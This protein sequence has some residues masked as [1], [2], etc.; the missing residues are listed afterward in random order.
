M[1]RY[2][3]LPEDKPRWPW[4]MGLVLLG[5]LTALA[6]MRYLS[7]R[8]TVFDL[9]V[10][11][12]NLTAMSQG[13]EWWRALNGHIQPVLWL[14][15]WLIRP[16]PDW[17][18]PL[19]LMVAQA[20]MLALPLPF[21]G[22]R[23]GV[24]AALA[25]FGYFAVWH[26][27][28]FDFHPD[29]LAIPLGFWFFFR[30]QDED[31]WGAA[32]AA[33]SLCLVKETFAL[34]AA[35][36]GVYLAFTRGGGPAGIFVSAAGL[37]WFWLATAKLIPFFTMDA[38][39]GVTAG[40]FAWI[41]GA[42]V[43]GK[44]WWVLMHPVDTLGHVLGDPRKLKYLGALFGSLAF[45]PLLSPGPLFTV[46]PTLALSLLSSR[47]DYYSVTNHYTAGLVAPLIVA[48]ARALPLAAEAVNARSGRLDRWAGTLFLVLL[49]GHVLLAAS[50][51]SIP[52]WRGGGGGGFW[53][54]ERDTRII[55]AMEKN[56]PDD[57]AE[58][59]I[60][61]NSLNWGKAVTR[62]FSNSFPLAVFEPHLAQ[63]SRQATLRDFRRYVL[64]GI[65]P[66]FPVTR[67]LARYVVLDLKRPWFMVDQG[68]EWKDGACRDKA[69][70]DAFLENL[71][72]A[73]RDFDTLVEDDGFLILKRKEP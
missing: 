8:S 33:L 49:A 27:G 47:P 64:T 18:T 43:L 28:L 23:Y 67:S 35:V 52:F 15:A 24:F 59:V 50:P 13:G 44:A 17:L 41:G 63:D 7:L 38:G 31:P 40:A 68:C 45:L 60:T 21:L 71:E 11:V 9:G 55:R 10:F 42:S 73:R 16:L 12:C 6:C 29:H 22:R 69:V 1:S 57:P 62:Y 34:Q 14:Y 66:N 32:L 48:F 36:F 4:T 26:N 39:V 3:I 37:A 65:K 2:G 5:A 54:D 20:F 61:Q 56:L 30:V 46:L 70:A 58:V 72:R 25:Y 51:L 19:G 53:P